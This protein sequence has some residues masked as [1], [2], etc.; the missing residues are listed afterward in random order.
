MWL[1]AKTVPSWQPTDPAATRPRDV[2]HHYRTV[3]VESGWAICSV[4]TGELLIWSEGSAPPYGPSGTTRVF[5][6]RD[7]AERVADGV[8]H[9]ERAMLTGFATGMLEDG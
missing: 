8:L 7:E 2:A 6:T 3:K 4:A 1:C 5:P 9:V